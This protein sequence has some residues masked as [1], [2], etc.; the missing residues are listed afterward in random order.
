MEKLKTEFL[1]QLAGFFKTTLS[2]EDIVNYLLALSDYDFASDIRYKLRVYKELIQAGLFMP[3]PVEIV[4]AINKHKPVHFYS[5]PALPPGPEEEGGFD[6]TAIKAAK[7]FFNFK[8]NAE[9]RI[10][11]K[12][13]EDAMWAAACGITVEQLATM[14]DKT[15]LRENRYKQWEIKH[16][17]LCVMLGGVTYNGW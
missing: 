6:W 14:T 17:D 10:K 16:S 9:A 11:I 5:P 3:K 4:A 15:P 1:E 12:E 8:T 2:K 13:I 7:K